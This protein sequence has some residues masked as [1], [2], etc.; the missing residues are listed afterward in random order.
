MR[1]SGESHGVSIVTD[2]LLLRD[3]REEDWQAAHAY[4]SDPEVARFMYT[5]RTER[6]EQTRAWLANVV[7]E[8][9]EQPRVRY[10]LAIV[11]Q[12][13][14]RLIGQ[15]GIGSSD[16]YPADGEVGFGYM[17][18]RDAWGQGYASEAARGIVDFAF[19]VLGARQVSAW[20]FE[21]N[22]A[23]ARV[24]EKAGLHV[25]LR[26]EGISPKSGQPRTSLRYTIFRE[27]W[28]PTPTDPDA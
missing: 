7:R 27:A 1:Q 22:R 23:S 20:C 25:E 6:P 2:R 19:G 13:D 5:H 4:R 17:L 11:L 21:A 8:S 24:L 15:I 26:E 28:R 3:F 16:E 10:T 12:A 18:H 9:R 14:G